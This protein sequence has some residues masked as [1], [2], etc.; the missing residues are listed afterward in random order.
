MEN[1]D[2]QFT[3]I[4]VTVRIKG[5]TTITNVATATSVTTD[6]VSGNNSASL[7]TTVAA[8]SAAGGGGNGGKG[9]KP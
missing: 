1:G 6:P 8:G 2:N 7:T 3:E 9:G 5:K 4:K